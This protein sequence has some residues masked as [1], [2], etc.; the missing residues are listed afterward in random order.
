MKKYF[1][2]TV[3]AVIAVCLCGCTL[4]NPNE[5]TEL[6]NAGAYTAPGISSPL[7]IDRTEQIG[8]KT[9]T[10]H[11]TV[12]PVEQEKL[13]TVVLTP[14][15]NAWAAFGK[16]LIPN[17]AQEIDSAVQ[18]E[19]M[20]ICVKDD[21]DRLWLSFELSKYSAG[22]MVFLD[23]EKDLNGSDLDSDWSYS[24]PHYR[25]QLVPPK[26]EITAE[27]AAEKMC[28]LLGSYSVLRFTPWNI[29]AGYDS[30]K[31]KGYYNIVL[32]PQMDGIPI[33]P[34]QISA[35]YS[36]DG[37]FLC[38]GTVFVQER[39]RTPVEAVLPLERAVEQFIANCPAYARTK[40]VVCQQIN[41]GYVMTSDKDIITL[42]PAWI[43]ECQEEVY[44]G[45]KSQISRTRYF[46]CG[47]LLENGEFWA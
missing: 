7:E 3:C 25:T 4:R 38:R 46:N 18:S 23:C 8:D 26:M 39:M 9:V 28:G 32:Q 29:I 12:M 22:D 41:L 15:I 45:D 34:E 47:F 21:D 14:D 11:A 19:N 5:T 6:S 44:Y 42:S 36:D 16:E 35:F 30:Q 1:V 20:N 31:E 37:L 2:S 10:I 43:F 27:S 24:I 17:Y 33:Y 13:F 40:N